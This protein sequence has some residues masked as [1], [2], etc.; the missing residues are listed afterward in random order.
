MWTSPFPWTTWSTFSNLSSPGT[1]HPKAVGLSPLRPA[2]GRL[3]VE[4][5]AASLGMAG[6]QIAPAVERPA[7]GLQMMGRAVTERP[8]AGRQMT[9]L[10]IAFMRGRLV[11]G[12]KTAGRL[13]VECSTVGLQLTVHPVKSRP[14]VPVAGRPV[15][16]HQASAALTPLCSRAVR[17]AAAFLKAAR[18]VVLRLFPDRRVP[19][20]PFCPCPG[21]LALQKTRG[22]SGRPPLRRP[23]KL[24]RPPRPCR[25]WRPP[26]VRLGGMCPYPPRSPGRWPPVG[27]GVVWSPILSRALWWMWAA[28]AT[29]RPPLW[30]IWC[31]LAILRAPTPVATC[32]H[33]AAT[34][35]ISFRGPVA[36]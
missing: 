9:R 16:E 34:W 33:A 36:A 14:I 25:P 5:S 23:C 29:G 15:V 1:V 10:L 7:V 24:R 12:P 19:V 27:P 2:A 11:V 28:P 13:E 20:C 8:A 22:R 30:R 6:R 35:T 31:A 3:V 21:R 18:V 4:C 32:R 17:L 26:W